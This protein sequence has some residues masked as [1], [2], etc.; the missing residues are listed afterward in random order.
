MQ[1][2][3]NTIFDNR[4]RLIRLL[5]RGGF[6]EVWLIED[7]KINNTQAAL[8]IY[9][10]GIGLDSDGTELFSQE[11]ALVFNLNHT[12]LLRPSYF[13]VCENQPYLVLPFCDKGSVKKFLGKITEKQ[14]WSFLHDVAAG[15]TYLH[16]QNPPVIHQDIKPDNI[17]MNSSG[18]FL[19]TD[20]GISTKARGTLRRSV[21]TSQSFTGGTL[22]YMGP[23]RFGK[24]NMPIKAS[25]V[26]ALG[27][28]LYE[29]ITGNAPFGEHG[30]LLLKSGAEIPDIQGAW[31]DSL[32]AVIY[33]C[34]SQQPWD[35]P[36]A[37]DLV[38]ITEK[39]LNDGNLANDVPN[40]EKPCR[41][42]GKRI[43]KKSA[44]CKYCGSPQEVKLCNACKK[45]IPV[46]SNFCPYCKSINK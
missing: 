43:P 20:F 2:K 37:H 44:F 11:F 17:L 1:H 42:C 19:I 41:K 5:G 24:D 29:L 38:T 26:W 8:K 4:Y 33:K 27:A 25:D 15:L 9:A 18:I 12:N 7:T 35:R 23:E 36:T 10:P 40:E 21:I 28:S 31:S 46:S 14:A 16:A 22:A 3:E 32:K 6:S 30:G 45:E 39:Q 34:L 13:D